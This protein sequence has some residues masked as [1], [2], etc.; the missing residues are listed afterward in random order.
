MVAA[1][2]YR[3]LWFRRVTRWLGVPVAAAALLVTLQI[4]GRGVVPE[5]QRLTAP[6]PDVETEIFSLTCLSPEQAASLLRPYLP[7]PQNPRWQAERFDVRAIDG[8]ISAVAVRAPR[9]TL[10]GVPRILARFE[11]DPT[12]ACRRRAP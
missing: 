2:A 4:I 6:P 5:V 10:D 1:M 8:G 7:I 12:A 3:R 11:K 9:A